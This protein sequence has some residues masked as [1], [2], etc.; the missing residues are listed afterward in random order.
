VG[1]FVAIPVPFLLENYLQTGIAVLVTFTPL[2]VLTLVAFFLTV[3]DD[4]GILPRQQV[5]LFAQRIRRSSPLLR[6]K[7]TFW[8]GQRFILKYCETCQLYRPPRCSHCSVCNNCVERFDHH[9]PWVSNCVGVRNYRTFYIFVLSCFALSALVFAFT[10][11]YLVDVSNQKVNIGASSNGFAG[12]ARSLS[13]GPTAASLVILI[14]TLF[15]LVFTGALGAFH[16]TLIFANKTTAESFKYTFRDRGSPFQPK[17]LQNLAKVLCSRKPSSKVKVHASVDPKFLELIRIDPKDLE[18]AAQ[19]AE[20]EPPWY[21]PF[22]SQTGSATYKYDRVV[23][24][25]PEQ[26]PTL[27]PLRT[28]SA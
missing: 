4:P 24:P 8:D 18:A 11:V 5:D 28:I 6:K 19:N 16:T 9:C 10:I 21:Q 2:L 7:E 12:F 22:P 13:N 25:A 15:G 26:Q 17:G 23:L 3:F 27:P 20:L 14:I 1:L